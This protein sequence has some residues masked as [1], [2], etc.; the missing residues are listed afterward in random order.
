MLLINN[1]PLID[2]RTAAA[3]LIPTFYISG[4]VLAAITLNNRERISSWIEKAKD[5]LG[6][7]ECLPRARECTACGA[8]QCQRHIVETESST[9]WLDEELDRAVGGFYAVILN[10]FIHSWFSA[11]STDEAFLHLLRQALR[12]ATCRFGVALQALN[13]PQLITEKLLPV[14][15]AHYEIMGQMQREGVTMDR[16]SGAFLL[17]DH[18]IHPAV[19]NRKSEIRYLR[20]VAKNLIPK[21]IHNQ[22]NYN[23]TVFYSLL[24]EL[25]ACWVLLPLLDVIADPNLL[26]ALIIVATDPPARRT[27]K[28]G[29]KVAFL[30]SFVGEKV[31]I[32]AGPEATYDFLANQTTLYS[33]M[34]FLKREGAVDILRFH[35][36]VDHL[37][38]E[39]QDPRITTDPAKLSSLQHQSEKLLA[40]Y[41]TMAAKATDLPQTD[42]LNE[43][44]EAIKDVLYGKWSR[45]FTKTPEYFQLIY[46]DK[47]IPEEADRRKKGSS[48]GG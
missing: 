1:S 26:N 37:N 3:V 43:A 41:K 33:F 17:H 42:G 12:D 4:L 22:Q 47:S 13:M 23:S 2:C 31:E 11:L 6:Y 5:Y 28:E 9:L 10:N 19:C 36:D 39:L 40:H 8:L 44:H 29:K 35:L 34:Q 45:A 21:L 16:Y 27:Y 32:M 30:D 25:L 7:K 46:S 15:F 14:V 18:P 48:G 20:F 24:R 38:A